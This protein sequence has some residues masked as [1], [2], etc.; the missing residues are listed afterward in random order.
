[1]LNAL[2]IGAPCKVNVHLRVKD[3]RSDGYHELES[4]FLALD[5]QDTLYIAEDGAAGETRLECLGDSAPAEKEFYSERNSVLRAARLFRERTGF[6]R[7]LHIGL[8]KRIPLGAG[9]G[10]GS[11]DAASALLVLN[12]LAGFP[13]SRET[14]GEMAAELGSDVPFF[15]SGGGAAFVSGRGEEI[16]G[17]AV[18][19]HIRVA[20]VNP[21]FPSSTAEAFRLLDARR[22]GGKAAW[23]PADREALIGALGRDPRG[24]PYTNDFLEVF[25]QTGS[26][27]VYGRI[28]EDLWKSG[29]DFAGLSGSGSTCF[30]VFTDKNR[31]L[32]AEIF[33]RKTWNFV[34][35]S[36]PLARSGTGV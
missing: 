29:A 23:K 14:L 34:R 3:R 1:M 10:G 24:W 16:R 12:K 20:L 22:A 5:L 2:R 25:A 36:F 26:G 30:G 9:L 15:L 7:P 33:L 32:R 35:L 21:G 19:R 18:P 17:I 31:A 4:I 6:D 8:E 13:L 11:S 28:L 27:E